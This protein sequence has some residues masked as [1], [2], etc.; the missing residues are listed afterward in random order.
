MNNNSH[1]VLDELYRISNLLDTDAG[2][3][4]FA[5][6][7]EGISNQIENIESDVLD[8]KRMVLS[9]CDDVYGIIAEIEKIKICSSARDNIISVVEKA[10]KDVYSCISTIEDAVS[11]IN[12]AKSAD[13]A[14]MA[15]SYLH[16]AHQCLS[17][18]LSN[19]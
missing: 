7:H 3:V 10:Q 13:S 1:T 4:E 14:K 15:A 9:D 16:D 8:L 11:S 6:L 19:L 17:E 18:A 5:I 2:T 12:R